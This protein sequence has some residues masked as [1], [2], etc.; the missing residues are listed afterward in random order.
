[1]APT[2]THLRGPAELAADVERAL[3]AVDS[4]GVQWR[5]TRFERY[6]ETLREAACRAPEPVAD[7][8][9]YLEAM[10]QGCQL[11][12][13]VGLSTAVEQHLL[14]AKLSEVLAGDALPPPEPEHDHPRNTLFELTFASL[15]AGRGFAVRITAN[16]ADVVGWHP[17][18][19]DERFVVECKRPAICAAKPRADLTI[20]RCLKRARQQIQRRQANWRGHRGMVALGI[21]RL[22]SQPHVGAATGVALSEMVGRALRGAAD[23]VRRV[24]EDRHLRLS[25]TVSVAGVVFVGMGYAEEEHVRYS[26]MNMHLFMLGNAPR[27]GRQLARALGVA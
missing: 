18:I 23:D 5:G 27:L 13:A 16:E 3:T 10:N 9:L 6:G 20:A 21:D 8:Q 4:L 7:V 22:W 14:T 17:E 15:L 25:P 19:P 26:I 1:M 12:A 2:V 11:I 24:A